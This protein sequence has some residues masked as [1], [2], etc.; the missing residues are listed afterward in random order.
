M[1]LATPADFMASIRQKKSQQLLQQIHASRKSGILLHLGRL[2][3]KDPYDQARSQIRA[4]P[5]KLTTLV[6]ISR[7][8]MTA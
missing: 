2:S 4:Y 1:N 7:L 5:R 6:E 3:L 8:Q